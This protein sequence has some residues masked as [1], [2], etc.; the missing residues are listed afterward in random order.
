MNVFTLWNFNSKLQVIHNAD[1]LAVIKAFL[2][3][4]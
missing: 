4:Q 1:S 3:T 2:R